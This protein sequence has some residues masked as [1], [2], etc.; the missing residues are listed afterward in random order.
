[1]L[2]SKGNFGGSEAGG[3]RLNNQ[4]YIFSTMSQGGKAGAAE[5]TGLTNLPADP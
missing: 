5:S 2:G 4:R 3:G 1:M